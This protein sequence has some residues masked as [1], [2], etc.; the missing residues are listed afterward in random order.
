MSGVI[1]GRLYLEDDIL[2]GRFSSVSLRY[3]MVALLFSWTVLV[4]HSSRYLFEITTVF[5]LSSCQL[6]FD[7]SGIL[8]LGFL[9][10]VAFR[11]VSTMTAPSWSEMPG[12]TETFFIN[13]GLFILD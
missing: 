6:A 9:L 2:K 7:Q 1:Q 8:R 5:A 4:V 11:E 13:P 3:F 12:M 10:I